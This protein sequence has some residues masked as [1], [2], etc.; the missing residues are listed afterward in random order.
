[1]ASRN[2]KAL[3]PLLFIICT[4]LNAR[5]NLDSLNIRYEIVAQNFNAHETILK[6]KLPPYLSTPEVMEQVRLSVQWPGDPPPK[7]KTIVYVFKE[8]A[9]IGDESKTGAIYFPGKG[10]KWQLEDWTPEEI[11]LVEP[12]VK[13]KLI[14]NTLLDSIFARGMT[15]HNEEIK[16]QIAH[17]FDMTVSE[18]DSIY[19]K[20]KYWKLY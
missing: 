2:F 9:K 7:D 15:I 16:D 6:I 11:P 10:Y 13:E 1:M 12:T 4:N 3:F 18:L 14:Y 5:S 8:T 17:Q 19:L 20:V